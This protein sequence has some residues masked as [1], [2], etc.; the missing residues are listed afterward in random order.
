MPAGSETFAHTRGRGGFRF[1]GPR[2]IE[3]S[4]GF[5]EPRLELREEDMSMSFEAGFHGRVGINLLRSMARKAM[6]MMVVLRII[7]P[8]TLRWS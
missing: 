6:L 8:Y 1:G 4:S 2:A 3:S 5:H 7:L